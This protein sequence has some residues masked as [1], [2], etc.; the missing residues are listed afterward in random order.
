[1]LFGRKAKLGWQGETHE[2][3]VTMELVEDLDEKVN[4]LATAIELSKGEIPKI[5]LIS[6]LYSTLLSH[7]GVKASKEEVYESIMSSPAESGDL[8]AA[9]RYVIDLCFPELETGERTAG[10]KSDG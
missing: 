4:V 5:T 6:K 8:V 10:K 9:A 7:V 1:M 2:I 3:T